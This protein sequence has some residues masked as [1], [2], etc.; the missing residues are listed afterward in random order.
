MEPDKRYTLTLHPRYEQVKWYSESYGRPGAMVIVDYY[1]PNAMAIVDYYQLP[2][3][4]M[5][6]PNMRSIIT[7]IFSSMSTEV[8]NY[9]IDQLRNR[10][11]AEIV[12]DNRFFN[13]NRNIKTTNDVINWF[14]TQFNADVK[15]K[16][17]K[18]NTS[19]EYLDQTT[20][21]TIKLQLDLTLNEIKPIYS[22]IT[23]ITSIVSPRQTISTNPTINPPIRPPTQ[24]TV[25]ASPKEKTGPLILPLPAMTGRSVSTTIPTRVT[26]YSKSDYDSTEYLYMFTPSVGKPFIIKIEYDIT[27][28]VDYVVVI[29]GLNFPVD[30]G[31]EMLDT[32][33]TVKDITQLKNYTSDYPVIASLL[34][35]IEL[36]Q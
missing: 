20:G 11:I 22:T 9:K 7:D 33:V 34:N 18:S 30:R 25:P 36:I 8:F 14:N 4:I 5:D 15:E 35:D 17:W 10:L 2:I 26:V 27:G 32:K 24:S 13:L 3:T 12:L 29:Y 23:S 19:F 16:S 31:Y 21:Q 28:Y 6:Q 1:Q